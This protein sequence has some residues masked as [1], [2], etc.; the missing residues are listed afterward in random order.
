MLHQHI[1]LC[2][3][4]YL[5]HI[6]AVTVVAFAIDKRRARRGKWRIPEARLLLFAALGGTLGAMAGMKICR[7]KTQHLKFKYGVPAIFILQLALVLYGLQ[8]NFRI[9]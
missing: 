5:L 7:H 6:N 8:G 4:A 9:I 3:L 2:V 1:V